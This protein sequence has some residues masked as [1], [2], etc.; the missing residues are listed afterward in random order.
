[1]YNA[2]PTFQYSLDFPYLNMA[3]M[4]K[5]NVIQTDIVK[6]DNEITWIGP[7]T[8]LDRKMSHSHCRALMMQLTSSLIIWLHIYL[9]LSTM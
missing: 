4:E 6:L 2:P 7:T 5:N 3:N 1:M 9:V 8:S